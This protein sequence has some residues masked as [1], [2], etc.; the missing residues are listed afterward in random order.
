MIEEWDRRIPFLVCR[1]V[2]GYLF[3]GFNFILGLKGRISLP[4]LHD[5]LKFSSSL[6]WIKFI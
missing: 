4:L 5:K 2:C 6:N 3:V 1:I